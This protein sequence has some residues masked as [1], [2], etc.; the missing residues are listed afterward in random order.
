MVSLGMAVEGRLVFLA[1]PTVWNGMFPHWYFIN[2]TGSSPFGA[3]GSGADLRS[4]WMGPTGC[5]WV[6][7]QNFKIPC[8]RNCQKRK[9]VV[10]T[11]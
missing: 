5:E 10:G 3:T 7:T 8:I 6:E 1:A 2:F 4:Y 9:I 11:S